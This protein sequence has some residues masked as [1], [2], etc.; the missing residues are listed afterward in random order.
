ML[1]KLENIGMISKAEIKLDGLTIIAG[2]NDSGKTT[3]GKMLYYLLVLKNKIIDKKDNFNI[4]DDEYNAFIFNTKDVI[5]DEKLEACISLQDE[6][7]KVIIEYSKQ[8][9]NREVNKKIHLTEYIEKIHQKNILFIDTPDILT[10]SKYIKNAEFLMS[11]N[12]LRF[13][14]P[15]QVSDLILRLSQDIITNKENEIYKKISK[16]IHGEVYYDGDR[17]DFYFKKDNLDKEVNIHNTSN[18]I[19][20]FGLLQI[21]IANETIKENSILILDEPE[22][23]LHPKWQLKYT[24]IIVELVKSG[25][26]VLVTSH[27]PYIVEALKVYSDKE[28]L[29]DKTNFYLAES[30]DGISSTIQDITNN[31]E[32]IFEKLSEPFDRLEKEEIDN[33]K[34]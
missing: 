11:Q 31:L 6:Y 30:E 32:P 24:E 7:H 2:W 5:R 18:G 16:I 28:N 27:S 12:N 20:M 14:I 8:S 15:H 22:V 19:K 29:A 17:D 1:L 4:N 25:V 33:F 26:I 10:K 23:H 21:L 34:W 9:L 13:F 3:I